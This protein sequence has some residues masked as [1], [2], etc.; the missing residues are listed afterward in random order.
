MEFVDAGA[1]RSNCCSVSVAQLP[2]LA[3][4]RK[5]PGAGLCTLVVDNPKGCA[6]VFGRDVSGS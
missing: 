2:G 5:W 3:F 1:V 6:D 4:E